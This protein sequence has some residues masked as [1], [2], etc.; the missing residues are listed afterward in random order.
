MTHLKILHIANCPQLLYLPSGMHR[1][2]ALEELSI[3]GCPELCR[4][5]QPQCG[6]YWSFITHIKRLSIGETREGQLIFRMLSRLQLRL[7]D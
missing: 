5:C 7:H 3:D 6:E 2:S 1:L 4:K